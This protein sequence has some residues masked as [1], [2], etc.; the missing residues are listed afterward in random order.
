[1]DGNDQIRGMALDEGARR[2]SCDGPHGGSE[3][4]C[5]GASVSD[6]EACAPQL[7]RLDHI[8]VH[9]R[10][11]VKRQRRVI[12][13]EVNHLCGDFVLIVQMDRFDNCFGCRA[14][15]T[16][17]IGKVKNNMRYFMD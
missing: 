6:M 11:V 13:E 9:V 2:A 7:R 4:P 16:S 12:L 15:S 17:G 10:G 5:L 8:W 1:M 3:D 14:M